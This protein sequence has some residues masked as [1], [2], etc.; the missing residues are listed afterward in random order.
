MIAITLFFALFFALAIFKVIQ[1][2]EERKKIHDLELQIARMQ[3][4]MEGWQP[5]APPKIPYTS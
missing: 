1:R 3:G 4:R 5:P 2:R